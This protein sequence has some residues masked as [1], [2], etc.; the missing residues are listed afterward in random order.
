MRNSVSKQSLYVFGF[1]AKR[2]PMSEGAIAAQVS[3]YAFF[4]RLAHLTAGAIVFAHALSPY[5]AAVPIVL[6]HRLLIPGLSLVALLSGLFNISRAKL[7][8]W[9]DNTTAYRLL[10]YGKIPLLF[11]F[12]PT[13]ASWFGYRGQAFAAVVLLFLG[14]NARFLRER[15]L[16]K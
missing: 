5:W 11:C 8:T 9:R 3:P 2:E 7:S 4:S 16:L 14:T 6:S 12:T 10:T 13:F 15:H 1:P